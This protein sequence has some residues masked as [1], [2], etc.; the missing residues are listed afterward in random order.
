MA[1]STNNII[2]H[3]LSGK[4]GD[5]LVFSQ[6]NGKTIVSMAPRKPTQESEKQKAHR[7]RFQQAIIYAKGAVK[8]SS[9][10][11]AYV[12][13]GKDK[14]LTANN[15]A[16]ADF[17]N[18]PQIETVDLSGYTGQAG[19]VIKVQATDDFKVKA[20][21]IKIEN[22]DGSLVEEGDAVEQGVY[23][24]Y[25]TTQE[26]ADWSGDKITIT[27]TDTPDNR[28]EKIETL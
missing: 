19:E 28:S 22:A 15:I 20:V 16:V 17:L 25:T 2:T 24:V 4:I 14:G 13:E 7:A 5:L 1:K 27:A 23:W 11:P 12:E 8:D 21:S 6:R 10:Q 18:A 3:G 26:N 9:L